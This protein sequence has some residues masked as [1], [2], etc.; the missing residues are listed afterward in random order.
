MSASADASTGSRLLDMALEDG[1]PRGPLGGLFPANLPIATLEDALKPIA[2]TWPHLHPLTGRSVKL[3]RKQ[4]K[5]A[6]AKHP[7][8]SMDKCAAIVL[9]TMEEIPR[10]SSLYY[11]LNLALRDQVREAVRPWRDYIWLL[12]HA[13]YELPP[14][15]ETVVFRGCK[16]SPA[17]LELELT[18]GFDF[19][20]SS[21]SSTATTQGVMQTFLGQSGPRT[22]MTIKLTE[23]VGRDLRDFSLYPGENEILLPPN[24]CFEVVD[25]FDAGHQL[26]MVQCQQTE[27]IDG[28]LD[29]SGVGGEPPLAAGVSDAVP[30]SAHGGGALQAT[31]G[32]LPSEEE[33]LAW[34]MQQSQLMA[35]E[36]A[37]IKKASTKTKG[38]QEEAT[39]SEVSPPTPSSDE[40]DAFMRKLG[41]SLEQVKEAT[42]LVWSSKELG[43]DGAKVVAHLLA[44]GRVPNLRVL[45][46]VCCIFPASAAHASTSHRLA[47]RCAL[48][49][50]PKC[51]HPLTCPFGSRP[52]VGPYSP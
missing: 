22:L 32:A 36:A 17:E 9:Y 41:T 23:A 8:I 18:A 40:M 39:T 43:P 34:A 49:F 21:F 3:A 6:Q 52:Q 20:W 27:T 16:K 44:S 29:L 15:A 28:I 47:S 14:S 31:A 45:R 19:T 37:A 11:A 4:A 46:Y 38:A 2:Q 50:A 42:E 24:M 1:A 10:E 5:R 48:A 30:S 25:S 26:V 13:L 12:L 33:Q 7:T 35:K 51:Q